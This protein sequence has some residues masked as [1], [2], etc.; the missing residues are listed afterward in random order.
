[1]TRNTS[2]KQPL[3]QRQSSQDSYGSV[4][5][6]PTSPPSSV[7]EGEIAVGDAEP[8]RSVEDDVLPETSPI[9]RT[10]SWQSAYIL[11][12]S[13]VVGSGIFAT[14][15]TI[16]QS[17]GSPGLSLL[18]WVVGAAIAA[19]GLAVSL[20][21]G[22][23][24]PRSGGDKVFIEFTYRRPRLLASTLFA[25]YAVLLGFT[26]SNCIIFAQYTLFAFGI[27]KDDDFWSKTLAVGL[28]TA[29][30][31]IHGVFPKTGIR[32]QNFL[33]WIKI[34]IIL[35]MILS[36]FYV[37]I[38]RPNIDAV[39][40]GQLAWEHLWDDSSWNWGVVATSLFK[41]FYSYAGLDNVTNVMN[42]VKNPVRTLRS[43]ALTALATAC[44]MYLL[45]NVA[46]FLVVPIDDI[47]GSGELV[48]ALFFEKLF[49]E[50]FGRIV[51]PMAVASSAIGNVLV[52]AFAMARIKQEI[53]RQG[54]LPYS[55]LLSSSRP[56]NS[57]L[58]GFLIHY[59]PS[60]LV[61]VLPTGDI[62]SLV[63][64]I[65]GY[66]GQMIALAVA[67]GL[68]KLRVERPDLKRPFRA[69]LPAVFLRVALSCAL[70]AAPFFRPPGETA[71]YAVVG[72]T[73]FALGVV[74]WY[75]WTIAI[76]RWRGTTLEEETHVLEDGTTITKLRYQ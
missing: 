71:T 36:G 53:A 42:E 34:A 8:S 45:I 6:T 62:Y 12:I 4:D 14:P 40:Q 68:V 56:F 37:V 22:C 10:L 23:M 7:D 44:G 61:M 41:V 57:P 27:N 13:R 1:M 35:F 25:L 51:L 3:L 64:E 52:V 20:E 31:I 67:I 50:S 73:I 18:L 9:G 30:T 72:L 28:L 59:I 76:P 58:G 75:M 60:F 2:Q 24:L 19:C 11:V 32:I 29:V 74:Y 63:L 33:G 26:A 47:R 69:W 65:D 70:L 38:F 39:P 54:F 48:A 21:Y 5:K 66:A 16:V 15:G 46:Y 49:G 43:V 55:S 17:V